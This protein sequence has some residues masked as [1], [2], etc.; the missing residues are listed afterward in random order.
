MSEAEEGLYAELGTTGSSAWGR[1]QSD[2]TSQLSVD[3]NL[4]TGTKSMPMAAVRGLATDNDLA[5]RKAAYEAEMRAWPTVAVACA[6]AMNSI[7][8]EANA[9]NRRRKWKQPLDASLYSNN[10]SL[11]TFAA[12]QSAV[13]A[14]LPDFRRW[15]R[16]KAKLVG[17]TTSSDNTMPSAAPRCRPAGQLL[18]VRARGSRYCGTER[19]SRRDCTSRP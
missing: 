14:S 3:V 15:M 1:L 11:E 5:V 18:A 8:G 12:M 7:K 2:L 13:H 4:P 10:V 16:V 9:V 6:A 17:D 19:D